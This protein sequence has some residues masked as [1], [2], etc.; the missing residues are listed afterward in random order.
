[1]KGRSTFFGRLF[2]SAALLLSTCALYC[3]SEDAQQ[4]EQ[5]LETLSSNISGRLRNLKA[6]SEDMTRRLE[7][8][9]R[10]LTTS[11]AEARE[12]RETSA[13]LSASLQSINRELTDCYANLTRYETKLKA[14]GKVI[15]V[16]A[17]IVIIRLLGMVAGL[18][19]MAR[20]VRLP[21]WVDIL[22]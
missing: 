16:L 10:S 6:Q 7:T 12:W 21:R 8:L 19:L 14:R 4:Q 11:Q 15:A 17:A 9:S 2:L 1:M 5:T 22:L 18:V 13:R 3:Y 20:G